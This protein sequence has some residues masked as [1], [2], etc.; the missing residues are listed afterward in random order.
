M[1]IRPAYV[2]L[3]LAAALGACG[4]GEA[5]KGPAVGGTSAARPADAAPTPAPPPAPT[6]TKVVILDVDGMS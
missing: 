3:L 6:E 1:R 5:E 4:K 2:L